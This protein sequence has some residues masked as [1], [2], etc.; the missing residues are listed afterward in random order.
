LKNTFKPRLPMA[1]KGFSM[2]SKKDIRKD[3]RIK[4]TVD[5]WDRI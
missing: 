2:K 4:I 5:N 3:K 1:P